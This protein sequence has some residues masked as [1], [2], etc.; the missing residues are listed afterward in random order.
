MVFLAYVALF[1]SLVLGVVGYGGVIQEPSSLIR[2]MFVVFLL[3][4]VVLILARAVQYLSTRREPP[5]RP[6]ERP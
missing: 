2:G 5:P 6:V 4:F 3:L 1:I